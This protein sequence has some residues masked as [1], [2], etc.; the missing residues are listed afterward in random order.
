M[1]FETRIFKIPICQGRKVYDFN[2]LGLFEFRYSDF[3]FY[4]LKLGCRQAVRHRSLEPGF[5]GSN[6]PTPAKHLQ[7]MDDG[8]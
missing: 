4:K 3:E 2:F 5:G 7:E 8:K 6:P 1:K